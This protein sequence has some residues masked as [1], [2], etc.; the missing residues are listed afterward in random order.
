MGGDFGPSVTVPAVVKSLSDNSLLTVTLL[1]DLGSFQNQYAKRLD[2]FA[3]RVR[4]VNCVD[5]VSM[6][7]TPSHALRHKQQSSMFQS[8]SMV[9]RNE[10]DACV[11]AG[12]TGAFMAMGKFVIKTFPG[13]DRP[14]VCAEMPTE[15]GS[16]LMLDL[17]AN[18]DCR[19]EHFLQFAIM[20]SEMAKVLFASKNPKVALL[21]IGE[22]ENKGNEQVR[23]AAELLE[24][25][26]NINYIGF[27]EGNDIYKG[28]ADVIVCDGFVGNAVLKASEGVARLIAHKI[29][30]FFQRNVAT[31][32]LGV[33][34]KNLFTTLFRQI[35]PSHY[36]GASFLGLQ[37]TVVVSH[38][39]IDV[40][41][42]ANAI[43][44]AYKQVQQNLPRK[45]Q[46]Q[47]NERSA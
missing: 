34:V 7:D 11:S 23:L 5:E 4:Y 19:S 46:Q 45:I 10:A 15:T 25:N 32:F 3:D 40:D 33:L 28:K 22:E 21:N 36:N 17:G 31:I 18:V 44:L 41:G 30:T 6:H 38:G 8:V 2:V 42:F 35:D 43:Q 13:V 14:A 37:G 47:I 24:K 16:C 27:V 29:R 20:G 1:G 39:N 12:N 9:S 26:K